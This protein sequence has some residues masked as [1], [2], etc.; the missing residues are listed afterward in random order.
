MDKTEQYC[1]KLNLK[2]KE[3]INELIYVPETSICESSSGEADETELIEQKVVEPK[4][5]SISQDNK[6]P[7]RSFVPI[8]PYKNK[9]HK[10]KTNSTRPSDF[11]DYTFFSN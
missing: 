1:I 11:Y 4:V 6:P 8:E 9:Q 7:A 3:P 2:K 10:M 5:H